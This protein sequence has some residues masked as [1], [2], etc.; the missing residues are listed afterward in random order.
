MYFLKELTRKSRI[1]I[2]FIRAK[3]SIWELL[4]YI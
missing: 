1:K 2:K 3:Y 4:L